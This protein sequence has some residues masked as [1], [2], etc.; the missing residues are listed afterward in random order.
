MCAE[1]TSKRPAA[2]RPSSC[3]PSTTEAGLARSSECPK[4]VGQLSE[5]WDIT[6]IRA[7]QAV[8]YEHA[9]ISVGTGL[10]GSG[11]ALPWADHFE[12]RAVVARSLSKR[13]C[14][15]RLLCR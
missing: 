6:R 4:N 14:Q 5:L 12:D 9:C 8:G 10:V 3:M 15:G 2:S 7:P 13:L 1:R 11:V